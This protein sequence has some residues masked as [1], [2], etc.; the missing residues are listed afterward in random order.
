MILAQPERPRDASIQPAAGAESLPQA[1]AGTRK[2]F[3]W[4]VVGEDTLKARE[5]NILGAQEGGPGVA[6]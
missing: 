1:V 6:G 4:P 3:N 5:V 2:R